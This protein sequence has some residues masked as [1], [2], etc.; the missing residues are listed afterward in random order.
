MAHYT[1]CI[2]GFTG[3]HL[4]CLEITTG[5]ELWRSQVPSG[6]AYVASVLVRDGLVFLGINGVIHCFDASNGTKLWTNELKGLGYGN[7]FLGSA[8]DTH[9]AA[10]SA[11]G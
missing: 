6:S 9:T 11:M 8:A 7:I 3:G 10:I 5:R 2:Y 1:E 4:T